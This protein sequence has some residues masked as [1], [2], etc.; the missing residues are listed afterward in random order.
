MQARRKLGGKESAL[1][2]R[3]AMMQAIRS[4]FL[5]R[6][7]LE[8]ETPEL[9]PAPA[10]E[11]YIDAVACGSWFL[12]TSP[13][14]CMKRLL[15]AG[16]EKVFQI[17]KCHRAG[18]RGDL[19]LPEY[20]MLEW[21]RAGADYFYLMTECEELLRSSADACGFGSDAI[22]YGSYK[23]DLRPPWEKISVIDAFDRHAPISMAAALKQGSFDDII[24]LNIG[25]LLGISKP[26]FLYDYPLSSGALAR[27]KK[28]R[29]DLVERFELYIA[30]ME[31]ANAFSE[32]TD[33]QEQ[34][35]RFNK[36][37]AVRRTL[38]KTVYPLP[39]KFLQDLEFMPAAAGIAL[40]ID[41]LAMIFTNSA[42][43]DEVVAF[44]PEDL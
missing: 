44:V 21:Y 38:N 4:F 5:A 17:C 27:R 6:N 2:L 35:R 36:A 37:V 34:R 25:P 18:E 29:A 8:I 39:E 41:R 10:P 19:H 33:A 1:R 13:E 42:I 23:I 3:A 14:V 9:A 30:G 31:I 32:L 22:V 16:Y 11:E 24:A 40:G 28:G 26:A 20:T 12:Q 43:I 7:Y 15:A